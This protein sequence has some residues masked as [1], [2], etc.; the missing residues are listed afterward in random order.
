MFHPHSVLLPIWYRT[1]F[2][3]NQLES[4][5]KISL[6]NLYYTS[7]K[8]PVLKKKKVVCLKKMGTGRQDGRT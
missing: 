6:W 8:P 1:A 5:T 2:S 4:G 3:L 7:E